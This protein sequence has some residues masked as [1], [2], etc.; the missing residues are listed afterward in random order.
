MRNLALGAGLT[1][2]TPLTSTA[3]SATQTGTDP[4]MQT[5]LS[6]VSF[7]SNNASGVW[8]L[9]GQIR[10]EGLSAYNLFGASG[11][12][13]QFGLTA[14]AIDP[15]VATPEP[16]TWLLCASAIGFGLFRRGRFKV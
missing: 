15:G 8:L 6:P 11:S 1:V 4:T 7:R 13:L 9:S 5:N 14:S 12:A 2:L 3:Y 16:G 10:L